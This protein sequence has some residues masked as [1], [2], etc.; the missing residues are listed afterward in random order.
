MLLV[1]ENVKVL[2]RIVRETETEEWIEPADQ[3]GGPTGP[4]ADCDP[5]EEDDCNEQAR[6]GIPGAASRHPA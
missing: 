6:T 5:D 1:N 4:S 2:R 3:N